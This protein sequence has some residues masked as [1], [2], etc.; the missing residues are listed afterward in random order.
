MPGGA[1]DVAVLILKPFL[2]SE[3][4]FLREALLWVAFQRFP[5]SEIN[6]DR[7]DMRFDSDIQE[8]YEP[9]IP[10]DGGWIT[11]E[12]SVRVGLPPNPEWE[13]LFD[14]DHYSYMTVTLIEELLANPSHHGYDIQELKKRLPI[15]KAREQA[16]E[17]WDK[18][19]E[20]H[21]EIVQAR[22]FVA[23]KS[24]QI[25]AFGRPYPED[26]QQ[27]WS[28]TEQEH[29]EIPSNFWR[30]SQIDWDKSAC[31]SDN[32]HYFHI[33]VPV[34]ELFTHFPPPEASVAQ[35]VQV[36]ADQY[37]LNDE[38]ASVSVPPSNRGR[39]SFDWPSFHA[40]VATRA[41]AGKL[42]NKQDSFIAE[43]QQW[44]REH[45]GREPARSTLLQQISP[46]Y[47]RFKREVKK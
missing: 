18:L 28:V 30:Q 17:E 23:L 9:R 10:D 3:I 13:H 21:I 43:M 2:L 4:C 33:Y 6:P 25:K 44:C 45:W 5:V 27:S 47:D 36:I 1:K 15:A 20:D 34:E 35:S 37:I 24:G 26:D 19:Y 7:V 38:D 12:E 14:D 31:D 29:V 8:D 42:P 41:A 46:H 11:T 40:E 39:K 16:Q 32:G 22:L